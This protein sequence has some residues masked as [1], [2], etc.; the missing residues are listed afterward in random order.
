MKLLPDSVRIFLVN[1]VLE[2]TGITSVLIGLF[3]LISVMSY[4]SFDPNILNLNNYEPKNL[5]GRL[6]ANISEILLQFF[7][8][9]SIL[10]CVVLTSCYAIASF[11]TYANITSSSS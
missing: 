5:G 9:S 8:Y 7:G 11:I 2:I 4:S 3:I 1:R 6:G 10:I